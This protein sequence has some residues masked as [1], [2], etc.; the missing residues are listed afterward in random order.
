M[1]I[2]HV[3]STTSDF[4]QSEEK[5][6]FSRGIGF[7]SVRNSYI[8]EPMSKAWNSPTYK[9]LYDQITTKETLLKK[10][11]IHLF[12]LDRDSLKREKY[13][14]SILYMP[15]NKYY[16]SVMRESTTKSTA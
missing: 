14:D 15:L 7:D 1:Q 5:S 12:F 8:I 2:P 3:K 10:R 13:R 4:Y 6:K 9:K 11:W 16:D